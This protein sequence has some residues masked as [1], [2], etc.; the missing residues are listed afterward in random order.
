MAGGL[1]FSP[2]RPDGGY[3]SGNNVVGPSYSGV[4]TDFVYGRSLQ[5]LGVGGLVTFTPQ[6]GGSDGYISVLLSDPNAP[7]LTCDYAVTIQHGPSHTYAID[8]ASSNDLG[9][10]ITG[11]P[12]T[13]AIEADGVYFYE[14]YGTA[15]ETLLYV[16]RQVPRSKYEVR[17]FASDAGG[18]VGFPLIN[19]VQ[20][21]VVSTER[22]ATLYSAGQWAADFGSNQPTLYCNIYEI[23]PRVG[24]GYP[25]KATLSR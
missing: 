22:Y 5:K 3:V 17:V 12:L 20:N 6:L 8:L 11:V 4:P 23:D 2:S 25:L 13:M 1:L 24:R 19:Q 7:L 9:A 10:A 14:N 21:I 18:S 16:S 15:S